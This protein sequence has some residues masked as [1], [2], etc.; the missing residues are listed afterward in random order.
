MNEIFNI[1]SDCIRQVERPPKGIPKA[2]WSPVFR[3]ECWWNKAKAAVVGE[4]AYI[5]MTGTCEK[6][7]TF[8]LPMFRTHS[9]QEIERTVGDFC[10]WRETWP[11]GRN[12]HDCLGWL[13]KH[14]LQGGYSVPITRPII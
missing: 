4:D 6:R 7:M 8:V 10:G 11:L 2:A 12:F 3:A 14:G 1:R 9:E 5:V 13:R